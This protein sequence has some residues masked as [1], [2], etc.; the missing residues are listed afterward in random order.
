MDRKFSQRFFSDWSKL[1][2]F[3]DDYFKVAQVTKF[4]LDKVQNAGK[5]RKCKLPPVFPF[6]RNFL[7]AF[8]LRIA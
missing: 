7:E 4:V 8:S 2:V 6:P 5:M 3:A 1:K